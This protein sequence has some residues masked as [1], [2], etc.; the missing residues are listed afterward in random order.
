MIERK[1][2]SDLSVLDFKTEKNASSCSLFQV[3]TSPKGFPKAR[4]FYA[5]LC[6]G[7]IPSSPS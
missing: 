6:E 3:N 2:K 5:T 4:R 1:K 7:N